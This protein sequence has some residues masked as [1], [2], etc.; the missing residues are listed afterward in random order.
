MAGQP[1]PPGDPGAQ[2]NIAAAITDV[3]EKVQLLIREEI[4]LA[5]AE[6]N[7]KVRKLVRGIVIGAAA[8]FFVLGALLLL[9][10]GFAWLSYE[11]LPT[12][13]GDFFWGFFVAAGIL[14]VFAGVAGYLAARAFKAGTP[15][16]P[17]LALEEARLIRETV[18]S[19]EPRKT[20]S[21]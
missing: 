10:H 8:G 20:I 2:Q 6:V 12:P 11:F 14:L 19:P 4:E 17:E 7:E 21:R 13:E 18:T 9:L 16:A 15:P 3:S 5:K 1:Q